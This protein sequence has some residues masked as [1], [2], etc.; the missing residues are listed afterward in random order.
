MKDLMAKERNKKK[1][2]FR[3]HATMCL[4]RLCV[5]IARA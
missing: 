4:Y 5:Y 2:G 3:E 1:A